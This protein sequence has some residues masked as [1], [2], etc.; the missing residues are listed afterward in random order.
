MRKSFTKII[1]FSAAI[2]ATVGV[3]VFSACGKSKVK[4]L[5]PDNLGAAEISSN[6][7]FAVEKG[8]YVYYINGRESYTA[9]NNDV[10][11]GAVMRISK[12]DLAARNYSSVDTVVP[13]I[14][15]SGN[16]NAGLDVY[17]D[18]VYYTT[19]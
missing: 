13:S 14:V 6:G 1:C 3:S 10:V 12:A 5:T 16:S 8:D 4:P 15:Y 2:V 11:K 7:G 17:G 9:S 19:P 18:R